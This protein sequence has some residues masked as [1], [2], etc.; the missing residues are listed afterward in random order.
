MTKQRFAND[1]VT[2]TKHVS[3]YMDNV[4]N[5]FEV[6]RFFKDCLAKEGHPIDAPL[7][8]STKASNFTR[9][10]C[11]HKSGKNKHAAYKAYFD[12]KPTLFFQCHACATGGMKFTFK[13]ELSADERKEYA[14]KMEEQRLKNISY[15]KKFKEERASA[16]RAIITE[17]NSAKPCVTHPYLKLKQVTVT[18]ADDLRI[19][20]KGNLLCPIRSITG[21][22]I[23]L[24]RIYWDKVKNKFEKRFFTGL[25]SNG[26]HV[27]GKLEGCET[28][29]FGEGIATCLTIREASN[30]PVICVYG[31]RFDSIAKIIH[32]KY[33]RAKLIFCCDISTNPNERSTSKDNARN[34]ITLIGTNSLYL[35]PNFAALE[36]TR[37]EMSESNLTDFND[38]FSELLKS[39]I[40][41]KA[42]LGIVRQQIQQYLIRSR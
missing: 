18:E 21:D 14:K 17:W 19:N 28:I 41:R 34:A 25:S 24:Q 10:S 1:A 30:A 37:D 9:F 32:E 13:K 35:L 20:A 6:E 4:I 29:Y 11:P 26:F 33:P 39:G 40:E 38:L 16:L 2:N 27:L 8:A 23:S 22:I 15:E 31:K 12:G 3:Y 5:S 7:K 42:A 36:M